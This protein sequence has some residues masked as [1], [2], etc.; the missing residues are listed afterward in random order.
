[1]K[2]F[3]YMI[4]I[5]ILFLASGI[6][7]SA[8]LDKADVETMDSLWS[9]SFAEDNT[10]HLMSLYSENAVMF[11]P[12]SEILEGK[13][14]IVAYLEGLKKVGFS[15]Y[16]ISSIDLDVKGDTAYTTALWEATR[17]AADG[18]VIKLDGNITNI[19]EKQDNGSWKIKF[20]SWN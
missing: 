8:A 3:K 15:E 6:A 13:S 14:E 10:G 1:M 11:P 7:S 2:A 5:P 4:L 19:L 20:Q 9:S 12:S 17:V 16:S 18:K